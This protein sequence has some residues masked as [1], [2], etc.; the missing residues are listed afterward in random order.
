MRRLIWGFAGRTYQIVANLLHWLICLVHNKFG[1]RLEFHY[2]FFMSVH[3]S[4]ASS[5]GLHF[6]AQVSIKN[7][8]VKKGKLISTFTQRPR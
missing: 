1:Q 5:A 7:I 2:Y 3:F 4:W 6:L 8:L